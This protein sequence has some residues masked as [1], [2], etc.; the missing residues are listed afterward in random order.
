MKR[1]SGFTLI[2]LLTVI[3]IIGILTG[4]VIGVAGNVQKKAAT[5][6]ARAEISALDLALERY[7]IDNGDYPDAADIAVPTSPTGYYSGNPSGYQAAGRKLFTALAG[8][9]AYSALTP[10]GTPVYF[11]FKESQV[12]SPTVNSYMVDPFGFAYGYHYDAASTGTKS[13]YNVVVPD[14]WSTSGQ[15]T[16][17][18]ATDNL[19]IYARWVTNWGSN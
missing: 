2:E 4:I 13:F 16:Q 5:S 15:T 14:I 17:P 8:R 11:E 7:K 3:T 12:G 19:Y 6:R 18:N 1:R 10:A 9:T